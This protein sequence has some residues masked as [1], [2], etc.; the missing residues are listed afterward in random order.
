MNRAG[1]ATI[2]LITAF[3]TG[4]AGL[5]ERKTEMMQ[6]QKWIQT[7]DADIQAAQIAGAETKAA[8]ELEDARRDLNVARN[9]FQ[10]K[11][12]SSA[13]SRAQLASQSALEAKEKTETK[14]KTKTK[15]RF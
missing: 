12:Y 3:L 7:A 8:D 5:T 6:A 4:C 11:N 9:Q 15:R 14:A 13:S 2:V 1:I 10:E